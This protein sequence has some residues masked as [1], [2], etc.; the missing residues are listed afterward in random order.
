MPEAQFR[1]SPVR[2]DEDLA[3]A[4]GLFR[5]YAAS[6][7]VDLAYQDFEGELASMPGKYA[8]PSGGLLLARSPDG[9]PLGCVALR[10]IAPDGCCEMKRLYVVPQARGTG[11]GRA[12]VDEILELA[13][14]IG[15]R[16]LRLDT[17][18][19]MID[20]QALYARL[21]FAP[22]DPYYE[23]PIAGTVF[24]ARAL[25]QDHDGTR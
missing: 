21:G 15:Y 16:E 9:T 12:L 23:T 6:L 19:S 17:L 22:I 4:V 7:G 11:L 1:I 8:P 24:M 10:A 2:S 18:P 14:A 5:A 25:G 20:A 3:A 13:V